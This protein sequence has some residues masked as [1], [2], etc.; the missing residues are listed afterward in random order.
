[1]AKKFRGLEVACILF[2]GCLASLAETHLPLRMDLLVLDQDQGHLLA[3]DFSDKRAG[4]VG[5]G[6]VE[7][8][9]PC[10]LCIHHCVP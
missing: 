8:R 10:S 7:Q 3:K 2:P 1:M 9:N 6:L 4:L 5:A